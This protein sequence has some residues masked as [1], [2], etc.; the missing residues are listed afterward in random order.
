MNIP[1]MSQKVEQLDTE[2]PVINQQNS[3]MGYN[4]RTSISPS[5][6]S[7]FNQFPLSI[8]WVDL[9]YVHRVE[10]KYVYLI[11]CPDKHH[12][13]KLI[14]FLLNIFLFIISMGIDSTCQKF[15]FILLGEKEGKEATLC[16]YE[17][18]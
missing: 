5:C 8:N 15:H 18:H 10:G 1:F 11:C 13:N 4:H 2:C 6:K 17:N 12:G 9:S 14:I 3:L 7:I 16:G